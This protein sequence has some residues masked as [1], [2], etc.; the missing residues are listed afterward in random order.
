M[1][2]SINKFL[3]GLAVFLIMLFL[4][5]SILFSFHIVALS[6]SRLKLKLV[7][8]LKYSSEKTYPEIFRYVFYFNHNSPSFLRHKQF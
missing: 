2:I 5:Y 4:A 8:F 6:K 1:S 7:S 3:K